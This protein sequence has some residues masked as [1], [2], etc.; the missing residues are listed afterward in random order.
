MKIAILSRNQKCYSTRRLVEA[1]T[2]R[3]H[4]ASVIDY[5]RCCLNLRSCSPSIIYNGS[6]LEKFDAVVPRIAAKHTEYGNA[7]VQQFQMMGTWV[8]NSS[9]AI[10]VSRDKLRCYQLLAKEGVGLPTTCF[11]HEQKDIESLVSAVG[12]APLI[13][14]VLQ[15]T[16]GCGVML[17]ESKKSAIATM[18]AFK[19]T[20]VPILVQ[21]FIPANGKDIRVLVVGN[22]VVASME[23]SAAAGEFRSNLHRG[24]SAKSVKLT[25]VEKALAIKVTKIMGLRAAGVDLLR[26]VNGPVILEVNSSPG[27]EGIEGSTGVDVAL[28]IVKYIEKSLFTSKVRNIKTKS[29]VLLSA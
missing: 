16:Q 7:V 18:E 11:G 4:Q 15:G 29:L 27:L 8:L 6:E 20:G 12:Q 28:A 23:R 22:K 9:E 3:G 5:L 26:S 2:L 10:A 1:A 21:E 19:S 25:R 14:K 24:G 17:A 13:L